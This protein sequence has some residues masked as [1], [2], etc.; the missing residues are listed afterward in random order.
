MA[1]TTLF[2]API[3]P[4][5]YPIS[6][7]SFGS[8][9]SWQPSSSVAQ[10]PTKSPFILLRVSSSTSSSTVD[11]QEEDEEESSSSDTLTNQS[12]GCKACGKAEIGWG[13]NGEGL[14]LIL[15]PPVVATAAK[16]R[17]WMKLLALGVSQEFQPPP[18]PPPPPQ[19]P[20]K[21]N[22]ATRN[23]GQ[24]NLRDEEKRRSS[25]KLFSI[26]WTKLGPSC[27]TELLNGEDN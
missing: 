7:S 14:A 12:G 2:S 11:K 27:L 9:S 21:L 5:L 10:S 24:G 23:K 19:P 8:K 1:A 22:Q 16:A 18:P 6:V 13:C 4:H 15:W 3:S 25:K 20:K 26:Q 17:A